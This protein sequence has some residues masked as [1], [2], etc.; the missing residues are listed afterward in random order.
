MRTRAPTIGAALGLLA[1]VLALAAPRPA[2]AQT[3]ESQVQSAADRLDQDRSQHLDLIAPRYFQRAAERLGDARQMLQQGGKI[4]DIQKRLAEVADALTRAEKLE[5]VGNLLLKDALS[6]RSDALAANAPQFAPDRWSDAE[7]SMR[8]AGKEVEDGDQNDARSKASEASRRYRLAEQRAIEVDVLGRARSLRDSALQANARDRAPRTLSRADS[9]L[10]NAQGILAN[11]PSKQAQARTLAEQAATQYRHARRLAAV[12]D[13]FRDRDA[14]IEQ[15][16]LRSE[17]QLGRIAD[18]VGYDAEFDQGLAPVADQIAA[19]IRSLHEDRANLEKTS[20]SLRQELK[21]ARGRTDS[22]E[23]RLAE[24]G[25]KQAQVSAE[26]QR[27]QRREQKLREIRAIF[28]QNEAEVL[29][30]GDELI[31]RLYGLQFPSASAEIRPDNFSLLTKVQRVLREFPDQSV[32]IAGHT[33]SRGNDDYN[34]ELSTRRAEAVR[35]YLMANM[36]LSGDRVSAKGFGESQ[37]IATNDTEA[38]R[39]KNR[40]IDVRI[41]LQGWEG[42]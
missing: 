19:S 1:A 6:A 18:S 36:A 23:S 12:A 14:G 5:D 20:A 10:S 29:L 3:V 24:L 42:S 33:D 26:L 38:G 22:L 28:D 7:S 35:E 17:A 2:A 4:G 30:S 8:D 21:D 37:P 15:L 40:R 32:V 31:I 27:R 25:E 16:V 39:A 41:D 11:D 9:L 13:T 34:Q